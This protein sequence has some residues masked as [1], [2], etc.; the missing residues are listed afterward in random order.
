MVMMIRQWGVVLVVVAVNCTYCTPVC[1]GSGLTA[2]M[3]GPV[4]YGAN[5]RTAVQY[6]Y[7]SS[8]IGGRELAQGFMVLVSLTRALLVWDSLL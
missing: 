5:R 3:L 6:M 4:K 7:R 2:E 1:G 8:G